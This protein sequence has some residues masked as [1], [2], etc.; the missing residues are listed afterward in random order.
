MKVNRKLNRTLHHWLQL[1]RAG[2]DAEAERALGTAFALLP[3]EAVPAGFADRV[4]MLAGLPPMPAAGLSQTAVWCLRA[5]IGL[6]LVVTALFLL[7][8]PSYLPAMLGIF[9]LSR[10]TG[11]VIDAF[12]GVVE[13]LGIGL[14]IWRAASTVGSILSS[15][16]SSPPYLAALAL[17]ALLSVAALRALH[18][19]VVSER[20]SRYVGSA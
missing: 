3:E 4:L 18:E 6:C 13:Q 14:V 11:F 15:V 7:V 17:G 1:E 10:L 12:V 20:S 2:D 8:I 9:H 16:L 5:V 19:V